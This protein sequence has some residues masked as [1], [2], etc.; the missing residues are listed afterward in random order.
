MFSK[1]IISLNNSKRLINH[2]PKFLFC[3]EN[4]NCKPEI[5]KCYY[6]TLNVSHDANKDQ[7]KQN[8]LNLGIY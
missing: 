4:I 3:S 6:Q 8:Y 1:I 2:T 7:I 5:K